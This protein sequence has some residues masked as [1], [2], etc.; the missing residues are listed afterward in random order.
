MPYRQPPVN[1]PVSPRALPR[2]IRAA[3][4][5]GV[6]PRPE[7]LDLLLGRYAADGGILCRSGTDAL[8]LALEATSRTQRGGPVLLPAYTCYEVGTAAIGASVRVGLYDVDPGTLE[9]DW[10]SVRAAAHRAPSA[11]VVA[12][13]HGAPVDWEAARAAADETGSLLVA[14]AAQAHGATWRGQPVGCAGDFTVLSFGRGKS[15]TG[16]GGGALLWRGEVAREL[17]DG[18]LARWKIASTPVEA[19]IPLMAA[20]QWC[21]SRPRLYGI[22]AALPFLR[23]GE[24]DYHP[25]TAPEAMARASAVFI[26]ANDQ[27]ASDEAVRRRANALEYDRCFAGRRDPTPDE[28]LPGVSGALRYPVLLPGGWESV[29]R[30]NL[31]RFGV[32]PGYP[33]TLRELPALESL[34]VERG[35]GLPGAERLVRELVTLPTHSG[36]TSAERRRLCEAALGKGAIPVGRSG[37]A[38]RPQTDDDG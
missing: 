28:R 11:L 36:I 9:P 21:F 13:L 20:L 31:V 2:A 1:S 8:R 22:P 5:T 10:S 17:G 18:L 33:T 15:W 30:S 35:A 6:D 37:I 27:L 29:R 19:R 7:L 34:L 23:L 14:D 26:L 38:P 3:V 4:A 12:P 16:L 32:G 24:T 25:P